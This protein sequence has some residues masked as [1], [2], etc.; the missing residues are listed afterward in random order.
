MSIIL[1]SLF[2]SDLRLTPDRELEEQCTSSLD[3]ILQAEQTAKRE[4]SPDHLALVTNYLENVQHY[5]SL[6]GQLQFERG[7]LFG[8]KIMLWITSQEILTPEQL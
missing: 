3:A 7:F 8:A 5:H 2:N 4:L 1:D 6:D